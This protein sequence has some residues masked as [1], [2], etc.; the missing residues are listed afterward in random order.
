MIPESLGI[1]TRRAQQIGSESAREPTELQGVQT[2]R[3]KDFVVGFQNFAKPRA[4][5]AKQDNAVPGE[6]VDYDEDDIR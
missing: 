3:A 6:K 5:Q 2:E 1:N 4:G